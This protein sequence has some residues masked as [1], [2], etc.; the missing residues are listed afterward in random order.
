MNEISDQVDDLLKRDLDRDEL[1]LK[2]WLTICHSD[3]D[4]NIVESQTVNRILALYEQEQSAA[5]A[6]HTG[7]I[8]NRFPDTRMQA[9]HILGGFIANTDISE[10]IRRTATVTLG[11]IANRLNQDLTTYESQIDE[12]P[13]VRD[14]LSIFA[15]LKNGVYPQVSSCIE[16]IAMKTKSPQITYESLKLLLQTNDD[17]SADILDKVL[18]HKQDYDTQKIEAIANAVSHVEDMSP[19]ALQI[20]TDYFNT[21]LPKEIHKLEKS[22]QKFQGLGKMASAFSTVGAIT[23]DDAASVI[24]TGRKAMQNIQELS[25]K[26]DI[27]DTSH[28]A[29]DDAPKQ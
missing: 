1:C 24:R 14:I 3:Q 4:Q 7:D 27:F 13:N 16:P 22:I 18:D 28:V 12:N 5:A 8:S 19:R 20:V 23:R 15:M 11:S 10:D 26:S 9:A 6:R 2:L 29:E 21:A 25:S 17:Y